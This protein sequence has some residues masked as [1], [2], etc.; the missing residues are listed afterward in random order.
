MH[1]ASLQNPSHFPVTLDV[2][3]NRKKGEQHIGVVRGLR[4]IRHPDIGKTDEEGMSDSIAD[5][6]ADGRLVR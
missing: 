2:F 5:H 4:T 1:Q 3:R 6:G